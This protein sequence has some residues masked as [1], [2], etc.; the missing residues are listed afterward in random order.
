MKFTD[1]FDIKNP[2]HI[3]AYK[4]LTTGNTGCWPE[5][6]IPDDVEMTVNWA[7][8]TAMELAN[9]FVELKVDDI[10]VSTEMEDVI[11]ARIAEYERRCKLWL[12][13]ENTPEG[14]AEQ[15]QWRAIRDELKGLLE[16]CPNA[17]S[18]NKF[19][20]QPLAEDK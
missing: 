20:I 2:E 5:G 4:H 15:A 14:C 10:A 6:F 16:V 13:S 7:V 12:M 17:R 19:L 9:A 1:W 8:W 11:K 18:L 3:A